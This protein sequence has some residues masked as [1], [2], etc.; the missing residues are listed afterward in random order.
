M[1]KTR[2]VLVLG[3]LLV[4]GTVLASD[5][6]EKAINAR[7]DE[8]L[9]AWKRDDGAAMAQVYLKEADIITPFGRR[10]NGRQE[11]EKLFSDEH[12]TFLKGTTLS[13]STR[14]YRF[15][16][17]DVAIVDWDATITNIV[18]PDGAAVPAQPLHSTMV[19]MERSGKWWVMAARP[20][21]AAPMPGAPPK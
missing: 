20:A 12:T 14:S 15:P 9:A 4:A 8:F 2:F 5:S 13:I 17:K 11:I 7:T 1:T 16:A 6:A 21:F 19:W 3:A 10:A 18:G